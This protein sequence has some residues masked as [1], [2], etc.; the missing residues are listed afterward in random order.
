[1]LTF[2]TEVDNSGGVADLTNR[3]TSLVAPKSGLYLVLGQIE[4]IGLHG[5]GRLGGIIPVRRLDGSTLRVA[6]GVFTP[7]PEDGPDFLSQPLG[8][9]ERMSTGQQV[10]LN[11]YQLTPRT[12]RLPGTDAGTW[13]SL[14]FLGD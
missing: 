3:P 5:P 2:D 11:I 7:I 9:V 8:A 6:V 14:T 4:W 1:M 13:I 12:Q 10:G